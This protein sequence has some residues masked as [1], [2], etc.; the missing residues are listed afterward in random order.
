MDLDEAWE[1]VMLRFDHIPSEYISRKNELIRNSLRRL[2]GHWTRS[3]PF[4]T[5]GQR[6]RT[7]CHKIPTNWVAGHLNGQDTSSLSKSLLVAASCRL[8][9]EAKGTTRGGADVSHVFIRDPTPANPW[10][11]PMPSHPLT[12]LH[13]RDPET[14]QP[15]M[16]AHNRTGCASSSF[17]GP[18]EA[19]LF[20]SFNSNNELHRGLS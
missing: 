17:R 9:G 10:F 16:A 12:S 8:N 4:L 6:I 7:V 11:P 19:A 13:S 20:F 1:E 3:R 14:M 5:R 18:E 2:P 15:V